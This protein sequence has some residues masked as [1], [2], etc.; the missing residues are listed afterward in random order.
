M[1]HSAGTLAELAEKMHVPVAGL[2]DTVRTYN[3]NL[4]G[5]DPLGRTVR[6]LP[7]RAAPYYAITVHAT[8]V[9]SA[10]GVTVDERL[11][12]LG[13]DGAPIGSLYAAGE[14]L[15]SGILQGS[16][17]CGGMLA[18]PA[19]AFGMALGEELARM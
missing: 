1:F 5:T 10:A 7:L 17:F 14:I 19:L 11:R 2:E 6:P 18:T 12:V 13:A 4:G 15:G 16:A 3:E 8:S 9:T